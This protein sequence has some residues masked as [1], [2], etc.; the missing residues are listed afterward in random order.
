MDIFRK[1][2]FNTFIYLCRISLIIK[3]YERSYK[4]PLLLATIGL[5]LTIVILVI[6]GFYKLFIKRKALPLLHPFDNITGQTI[7]E[8][9]E[10]QKVL[11]SEDEDGDGKRKN[12]LAQA[13][14]FFVSAENVYSMSMLLQS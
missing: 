13:R 9:H 14:L 3:R 10:E 7:S 12:N 4:I 8:F 11:V 5:P 1:I 6:I 2:S